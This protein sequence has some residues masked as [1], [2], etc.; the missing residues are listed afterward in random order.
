[1]RLFG[2][3]LLVSFGLATHASADLIGE[4]DFQ[5]ASNLGKA[6]RGTDLVLNNS[7]GTIGQVSGVE[8][9]DFAATIGLGDSFSL[10][11]G[12]DPNGGSSAYVNEYSLVFDV[13]LPAASAGT[14]RSFFQTS[15]A[16]DGND[17]DY[18][19]S[20]D[21]NLGVGAIG[22]ADQALA[23]ENWYRIVF[24]ADIGSDI[25]GVIGSSFLTTVTDIEGNS[26]HYYHA[27]QGLDG[28]HSLYSTA[29]EN[30]M[31]FFAD[32]DGEDNELHVTKLAMFDEA[33]SLDS[34][35]ALGSVNTAVPEP[36]AFLLA[37]LGLTGVVWAGYRRRKQAI[38]K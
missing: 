24:S 6:T 5:D 1:M 16:P 19:V 14:W 29:N 38:N 23:D 27:S 36:S 11:H 34:A 13:Y 35:I 20:P 21:G 2:L 30:I 22:Y 9:G 32:N 15:T 26:W 12:L 10:S 3:A 17:G 18:W 4:W 28:R 33:L 8:S 7:N 37:S 25:D 31:H